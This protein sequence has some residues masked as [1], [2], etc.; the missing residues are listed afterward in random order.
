MVGDFDCCRRS[1]MPE[2]S[3]DTKA[4]RKIG[5]QPIA[6]SLLSF[7][8]GRTADQMLQAH[9]LGLLPLRVL[10]PEECRETTC[11]VLNGS[12]LLRVVLFGELRDERPVAEINET[13]Q[14]PHDDCDGASGLPDFQNLLSVVVMSRHP[15]RTW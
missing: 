6:F 4:A 8:Q 15:E 10:L 1:I 13:A 12:R 5:Q 3:P 14:T 7:R 9:D 11:H 2:R